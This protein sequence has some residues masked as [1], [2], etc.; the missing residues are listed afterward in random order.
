MRL[1]ERLHPFSDH[2]HDALFITFDEL[3]AVPNFLDQVGD[4]DDRQRIGAE[5]LQPLNGGQRFQ[6][7][8]KPVYD[9]VPTGTIRF[10]ARWAK[11]PS[12]LR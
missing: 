1:K 7:G 4:I 12:R 3:N 5:N 2:E 8:R 9:A 11:F 10:L 6:R